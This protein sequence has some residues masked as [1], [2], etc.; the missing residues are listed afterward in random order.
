MA[1]NTERHSFWI[2][3]TDRKTG[4]R[5]RGVDFTEVNQRQRQGSPNVVNKLF[6]GDPEEESSTFGMKPRKLDLAR[7]SMSASELYEAARMALAKGFVRKYRSLK[8]ALEWR[9]N[10]AAFQEVFTKAITRLSDGVESKA[11][12]DARGDAFGFGYKERTRRRPQLSGR[13]ATEVGKAIGTKPSEERERPVKKFKP[14][15]K[16]VALTKDG[17]KTYDY[18]NAK[19]KPPRFKLVPKAFKKGSD[20]HIIAT[21]AAAA[22][23]T[24][25]KSLAT[26]LA[27]EFQLTKGMAH[28]HAA[29]MVK[30]FQ[31]D[32]AL[33]FTT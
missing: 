31:A 32:G 9:I 5:S 33:K 14:V 12:S 15:G 6:I 16:G 2:G 24:S 26:F 27:D 21:K 19:G 29:E 25:Q 1:R 13:D 3:D 18:R 7:R 30:A 8:K 4:K 10:E 23:V 11:P 22:G 17:K 20:E 28:V